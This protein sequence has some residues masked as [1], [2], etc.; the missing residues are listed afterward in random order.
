MLQYLKLMLVEL[1]HYQM[2]HNLS[3]KIKTEGFDTIQ[4]E[5]LGLDK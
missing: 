1:E 5:A 3:L 2:F 4:W